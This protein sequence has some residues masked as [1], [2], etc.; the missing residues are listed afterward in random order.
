MVVQSSYK[1]DSTKQLEEKTSRV[2]T[3]S[4]SGTPPPGYSY[5]PGRREFSTVEA[6][7]WQEEAPGHHL[8]IGDWMAVWDTEFSLW[9][10]YNLQTQ[11]STWQKPRDLEHLNF[12]NMSS[13]EPG[14]PIL[15]TS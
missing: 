14:D 3:A 1:D 5:Y 12:R 7:G 4:N 6:D 13:A 15:K 9:Y 10:Y 11:D 8:R 2:T